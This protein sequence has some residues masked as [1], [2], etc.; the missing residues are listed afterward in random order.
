MRNK[1]KK[2]I[3]LTGGHAATAALATIEVLKHD[4]NVEWDIYWAG[5]AKAMEG[6]RVRTLESEVFPKMGIK[7]IDIPAG[8]LQ[9]KFTRHSIASLSKVPFGF[10]CSIKELLRVKPDIVLSFGG[11]IGL[12]VVV[13]ARLLSIP[14]IL[15]EQTVEVGLANKISSYF[16]NLSVLS[17]HASQKHFNKKYSVVVGNPV[18]S[19][20]MRVNT[21]KSIGNPATIFVTGG[22]R[23]A[24][25]IN[26]T[27][28]SALKELVDKYK[29]IHQTG[30][31]DYEKARR[32]Q[33]NLPSSTRSSYEPISLIHPLEISKVYGK[34]DLVIGRS[35]ANTVSEIAAIN[36][37]AIFI[38]IPWAR[39]DEQRK[40]AQLAVREGFAV[41]LEQGELTPDKLVKEIERVVVN[42][43]RMAK[44]RP[45]SEFNIDRDAASNLVELAK[46][47]AK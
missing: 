28:F 13:A 18:M 12:A 47:H 2:T 5:T 3:V 9:R 36:R 26:E 31:I 23:G 7:W 4:T 29:V 21:K 44:P 8:R 46:K 1:D 41:L 14:V 38:P 45:E 39:Y 15:H 37:P 11:F 19:S 10:A 32:L 43:D 34:A 16:V 35:G 33:D 22:S 27:I 42:W 6:K 20:V 17:R 24:S 40:N 25:V 30:A